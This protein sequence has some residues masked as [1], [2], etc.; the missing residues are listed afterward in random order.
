MSVWRPL[1]TCPGRTTYC[2]KL[3]AEAYCGAGKKPRPTVTGDD[4]RG[5]S[6]V[7][8]II[9]VRDDAVDAAFS[10][11]VGRTTRGTAAFSTAL[12]TL[13]RAADRVTGRIGALDAG[14]TVAAF[15]I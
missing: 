12:T 8:T 7:G 1:P 6:G 4:A 15:R 2:T 13:G 14:K 9:L 10:V 11:G 5:G 3:G